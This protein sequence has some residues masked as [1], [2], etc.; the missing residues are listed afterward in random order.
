MVA[1]KAEE[2]TADVHM[3]V[4]GLALQNQR[5]RQQEEGKVLSEV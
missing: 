2:V 5:G 3:H 1:S 4:G